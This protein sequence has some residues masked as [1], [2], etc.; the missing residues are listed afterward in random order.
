MTIEMYNVYTKLQMKN[1]CSQTLED[2]SKTCFIFASAFTF[3]F[4][5]HLA[6]ASAVKIPHLSC[7]SR[8]RSWVGDLNVLMQDCLIEAKY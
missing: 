8:Q 6:E 3:A 2:R 5:K 7:V 4:S 1:Y